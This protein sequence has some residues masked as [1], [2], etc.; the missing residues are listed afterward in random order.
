MSRAAMMSTLIEFRMWSRFATQRGFAARHVVK[1]AY[2]M[3]DGPWFQR[4][5]VNEVCIVLWVPGAARHWNYIPL[6]VELYLPH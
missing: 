3:P 1:R 2:T 5:V 6:C 4:L